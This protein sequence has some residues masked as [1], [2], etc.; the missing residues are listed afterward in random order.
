M[1]RNSRK[2]RKQKNRELKNKERQ[3]RQARL[4]HRNR[5]LKT[6]ADMAAE[7][8]GQDH[9]AAPSIL[10]HYT[11]GAR[12]KLILKSGEIRPATAGIE[13]GERPAVWFSSNPVWE[14]TANK[15]LVDPWTGEVRSLTKQETHKYAGGLARIAVSPKTA[16]TNWEGFCRESG[17]SMK[18]LAGLKKAAYSMGSR[19]SQWFVSFLPVCQERWLSVELWDGD[20]WIP[21]PKRA[22][23]LL[24]KLA[25][26]FFLN[27]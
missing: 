8:S 11:C 9:S 21:T 7:S 25:S 16:P 26:R 6:L 10:W 20:K 12:L 23:T 3:Q 13:K 1:S 17:A 4:I 27:R 5:T 22:K 18:T 24:E 14:E 15:L 19:P 2:Q